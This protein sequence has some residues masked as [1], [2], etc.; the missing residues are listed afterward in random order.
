MKMAK[1]YSKYF[2]KKKDNY[3]WLAGPDGKR[4]GKAES[5][6]KEGVKT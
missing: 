1:T 6:W 5:T 2:G 3:L 4:S